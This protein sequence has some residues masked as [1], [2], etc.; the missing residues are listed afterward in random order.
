MP[1]SL[2]SPCANILVFD[3]GVGGLSIAAEI[4]KQ[5]PNCQ[6]SYCS[7]N[8]AFP[9]GTKGEVELVARVDKVLK[10]VCGSYDIDIIVI[11]CNSASTLAL[12]HI[13]THFKQPI[14]G[15]VPAVK[16]AAQISRSKHIGLL[17]TPGT[18]SRAYTQ[19][20]ID[21]FAGDCEVT[22]TGSSELV[23]LAEQKLRGSIITSAQLA[24]IL[25]PFEKP[26]LDTL[27]LACTHFPLLK[28]EIQAHLGDS[29]TLVDSTDAIARRVS[30]LITK[31]PQTAASKNDTKRENISIFTEK[32]SETEALKSALHNYTLDKI[33][34]VEIT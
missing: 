21:D 24:P 31:M 30:Y 28:D 25:K 20:L 3:S 27:I 9:Y 1:N 16:P 11:A 5:L 19:N 33:E 12:P 4:Q 29:V 7:D 18:V 17:A 23:L 32:T 2:L 15:V 8:A 34:Y 26:A 14:V 22:L 13:R 6:I 10:G